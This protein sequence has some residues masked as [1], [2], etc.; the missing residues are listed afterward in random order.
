MNP[1]TEFLW[2]DARKAYQAPEPPED[3]T[4]QRWAGLLFETTCQV[5][6]RVLL[7]R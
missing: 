4:E 2:R 3:F 7:E 6:S 1:E 5:C